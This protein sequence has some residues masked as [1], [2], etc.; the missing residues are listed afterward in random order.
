MED[1]KKTKCKCFNCST[2]I[3]S[4]YRTMFTNPK[5]Q[6]KQQHQEQQVLKDL[7]M[8]KLC[9]CF[10]GIRRIDYSK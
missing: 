1:D 10:D 3:Y 4:K 7:D 2:Q 6:H 9:H 8:V 5:Q